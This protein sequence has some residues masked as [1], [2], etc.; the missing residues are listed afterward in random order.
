MAPSTPGHPQS[1]SVP[2][3]AAPCACHDAPAAEGEPRKAVAVDPAIKRRNLARLRRIEGQVRG[4][5]RMVD[6]DRYC[7]DVLM[8]IVSVQEALRAVSRELLRNH[9]THCVADAMRRGPDE[10]AAVRDEV[11]NL[12]AAHLR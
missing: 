6:D 10:A 12:F 1:P 9:L 3:V 8:Q 4:L 11:V 2:A 5:H 7:A